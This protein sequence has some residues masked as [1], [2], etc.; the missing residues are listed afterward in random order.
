MNRQSNIAIVGA[1]IGGLAAASFLRAQGHEVTVYE[2]EQAPVFGG[3][4]LLL[5]PMGIDVLDRLDLATDA[6]KYGAPVARIEGRDLANPRARLDIAY[7]PTGNGTHALGLDRATLILLLM[8]EAQ[9]RGVR[10]ELGKRILAAATTGHPYL[11]IEGG[12]QAGPFDMLIDAGGASSPLSPLVTR[13][14]RFGVLWVNVALPAGES[15]L[16]GTLRQRYLGAERM[17]GVL[18]IGRIPG[19]QVPRATLYWSIQRDDLPAWQDQDFARFKED[20]T[21]FWPDLGFLMDPLE[22]HEDLTFSPLRR[23]TL[24]KTAWRR[25]AR[26][27]DAAQQSVPLLSQGAAV[28]LVDA[29]ALADCVARHGVRHAALR[30]MTRRKPHIWA[31]QGAARLFTPMFQSRFSVQ[32]GLRNLLLGPLAGS[33]AF[34]KTA[35]RIAGGRLLPPVIGGGSPDSSDT[36]TPA[37]V[38]PIREPGE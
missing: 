34:E 5:P 27:G 25:V 30:Y 33:R 12:T 32:A 18:P 36:S 31:Y 37:V 16:G 29:M 2:Q 7:D 9:A 3:V 35:A 4:G 23:G 15:D 22:R 38:A 6:R 28:A 21:E 13:Q 1:G 24:T 17:A 8:E 10:F 19:D 11:R 14:M 26:V 20:V